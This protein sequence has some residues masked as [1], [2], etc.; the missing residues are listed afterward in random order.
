MAPF[1]HR[2]LVDGHKIVLLW[3]VKIKQ[4]HQIAFD[5]AIVPFVFDRHTIGEHGMKR[6]VNSHQRGQ[7]GPQQFTDRFVLCF[8][9]YFGVEPRDRVLQAATEH[10]IG[11]GIPLGGRFP[12]G[13]DQHCSHLA[14]RVRLLSRQQMTIRIQRQCDCPMPH[15]GLDYLWVR[16]GN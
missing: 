14:Y 1:D 10:H 2:E 16:A 12:G 11:K 6:A 3:S 15:H 4:P 9:W 5:G 8:R 7:L 13:A